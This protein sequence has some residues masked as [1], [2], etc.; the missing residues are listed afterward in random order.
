MMLKC[1]WSGGVLGLMMLKCDALFPCSRKRRSSETRAAHG[2]ENA[3]GG[4][5]DVENRVRERQQSCQIKNKKSFIGTTHNLLQ[6]K[7]MG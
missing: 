6:P 7:R 1:F 3:E 4:W 2:D 5:T